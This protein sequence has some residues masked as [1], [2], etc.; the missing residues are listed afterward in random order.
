MRI[1]IPGNRPFNRPIVQFLLLSACLHLAA[2]MILQPASGKRSSDTLVIHARLAGP[3]PAKTSIS[4]TPQA[5]VP[6]PAKPVPTPATPRAAAEPAPLAPMAPTAP[7]P[8]A[9]IA[10]PVQAATGPIFSAPPPTPAPS[11]TIGPATTPSGP[12]TKLPSL[13]LAVDTTWYL[14][15]QVDSQPKAID[16]IEPAYPAEAR[17]RNLDGSLKLML[18]I[19]DLGRVQTAEV[20]EAEPPGIFDES[21]LAAFR[22]A[23]FRPAMKDGRPVR[24][25]AYIRVEYKLRD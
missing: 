14:A 25:Q 6:V 10:A 23:R 13:P 18:K 4:P 2:I 11:Q 22:N 20:V 1:V 9:P 7:S 15:R 24:C 16:K 12:E 8:S 17:L 21:A 5:P 19:D 3:I